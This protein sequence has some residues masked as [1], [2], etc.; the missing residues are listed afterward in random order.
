MPRPSAATPLVSSGLRHGEA[1]QSYLLLHDSIRSDRTPGETDVTA[2]VPLLGSTPEERMRLGSVSLGL[3][4]RV[5]SGT[6]AGT[7][8]LPAAYLMA[9]L[10]GRVSDPVPLALHLG[11]WTAAWSDDDIAHWLDDP[12]RPG[13]TP[14]GLLG[15][16]FLQAPESLK[17]VFEEAG[18]RLIAHLGL[19]G[20]FSVPSPEAG[21]RAART[22]RAA[23]DATVSLVGGKRVA[24]NRARAA[25]AQWERV[26]S[27]ASRDAHRTMPFGDASQWARLFTQARLP[28]GLAAVPAL[29]RWGR[30]E[31]ASGSSERHQ[32]GIALIKA[33]VGSEAFGKSKTSENPGM[34]RALKEDHLRER[35]ELFLLLADVHRSEPEAGAW[36][37]ELPFAPETVVALQ[38]NT[39]RPGLLETAWDDVTRTWWSF[40][41]P[42]SAPSG[43]RTRSRPRV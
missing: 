4:H 26:V 25:A 13:L 22:F 6:F 2:Q 19:M 43:G 37:E 20:T 18:N 17:G 10:A 14:R 28:W 21:D 27:N 11:H 1:V 40:R 3:R 5:P 23:V 36:F 31:L 24:E 42:E 8:S 15:W 7:W 38:R 33:I 12:C 30:T 9:H 35:V 34:E 32:G 16:C 29:V 41:I 39:G